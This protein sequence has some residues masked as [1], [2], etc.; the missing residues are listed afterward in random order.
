[1][2]YF[3]D[4]AGISGSD[5]APTADHS[6]VDDTH[7]RRLVE[8]ASTHPIF[9]HSISVGILAQSVV[10]LSVKGLTLLDKC[11]ILRRDVHGL[12]QKT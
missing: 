6:I 12:G 4:S 1:M 3:I 5:A 7:Y 10:Q 9:M 2:N 11:N 8:V